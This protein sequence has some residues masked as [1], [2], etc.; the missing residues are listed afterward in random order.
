MKRIGLLFVCL[1]LAI[2]PFY[3]ARVDTVMVNSPSMNKEVKVLVIV[4]KAATAPKYVFCPVVYLLHGYG[5]NAKTWIDVQPELPQIA[6][7][8]GI[9]FVCPD[10]KNSWYWD[11]PLNQD[12]R[13]E[14]FVSSELIDYIDSHYK[15]LTNRRFRA[16]TGLS[17]G[18]HGALWNAIRHKDVFG[19]AG[20]TSGGVDIR[21][22]PKN[23]QMAE[24]L[25]EWETNKEVW[26]AHT[27]VN[28]IDSLQNGDLALIID[29]GEADFFLEVN[30][31]LHN[32]L[33]ERKIDHDFI[34]RPGGHTGTYWSN[35]IDYQILFF[36]K[37]FRKQSAEK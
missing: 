23:W 26:E 34:T 9:I 22:F 33:L 11:S 20:S 16:I 6:D 13:Y 31:D 10:G 12:Y 28:Q 21:P 25:G 3:A 18:G 7:E 14:T 24:Q 32:R 8:K 27:V 15:T 19:A 2:A 5:G 17:M 36:S 37:F 30:K 1:W 4:P 35:S 29:C